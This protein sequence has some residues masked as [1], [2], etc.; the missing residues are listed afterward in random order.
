MAEFNLPEGTWRFRAD[1]L[2]SRYWG[3]GTILAD[4]DN[5]IGIDPGNAGLSLTLEKSP[6]VPLS[7]IKVYA[8]D[9]DG[10][11]LGKS[12]TTSGSGQAVF[13]LPQRDYMRSPSPWR[14]SKPI[15]LPPPEATRASME[16]L[17]PMATSYFL[18]RR[19]P[20]RS[21]PTTWAA[22]T[23]QRRPPWRTGPS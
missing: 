16:R 8:F 19:R 5:S 17:M 22:N 6:G 11:Y 23:G 20:I 2:G 14:A 21:G 1:Y 13:D 18:C 9:S 10:T 15:S 12:Q 3:T 7:G 4:Q